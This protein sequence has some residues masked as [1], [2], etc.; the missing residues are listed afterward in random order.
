LRRFDKAYVVDKAIGDGDLM[1]LVHNLIL[2]LVAS[3]NIPPMNL[4][5]S[6]GDKTVLAALGTL[7]QWHGRKVA[8]LLYHKT[9][10]VPLI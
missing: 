5:A 1:F 7:P 10:S 9:N 6:L 8:I 2:L 4:L 3:R